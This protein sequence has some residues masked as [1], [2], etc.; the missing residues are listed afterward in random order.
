MES[1][2][3]FAIITHLESIVMYLT[4]FFVDINQTFAGMNM[5]IITGRILLA[6]VEWLLQQIF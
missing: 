5:F 3:L 1:V 6:A 2:C 4:S